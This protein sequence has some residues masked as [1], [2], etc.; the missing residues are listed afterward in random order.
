MDPL[1]LGIIGLHHQHPRWYHPLWEHLDEFTPRAIAEEDG[2]F[3]ASQKDF[4]GLDAVTDYHELLARDDI[5]VVIIFLPHSRMP[6]AVEAA[7]RAGKHV[8]VEKPCAANLA[9]MEKI[10]ETART[11]PEVVISAPYVWRTHPVSERLH[12][13]VNDGL[14]GDITAVEGRLNAGG[15]HRYIRDN[16]PWVLLREEGGGP[17]W[18]L[19]VHWIDYFRWIT[20]AEITAVSGAV[21]GPDG[22]PERTIEDNAQAVLTFDNGAVGILD[23]SYSLPDAYPGSRDIAVALRGTKGT[24]SWI[25]AWEGNLDQY[26]LV[27]DQNGSGKQTA[28]RMKIQSR[29]IP[30]YGGQMAWQWLKEFAMATLIGGEPHVTVDDMLAAVRVADAFYRSVESGR[31]EDVESSGA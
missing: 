4:Y 30:G 13:A 10:A 20:G 14:L 12:N 3:L 17:M 27:G 24:A 31:R 9:G 1:G 15:P 23:I 16:C 18:N 28:K 6:E 29:D 19:G 26:L 8:I 2:D 22:P 11:H 5:D 21:S 25:P 7:A